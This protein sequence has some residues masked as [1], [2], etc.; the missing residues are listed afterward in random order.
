MKK[1]M[2]AVILSGIVLF[3]WGFFSWAVLPWHNTVANEFTSEQTVA[4]VL[5]E[6]APGAGVYY[7]PFAEE[8]RGAGETG[9][10][11]NVLPDGFDMNMGKLMGQALLGQM[12]AAFLVLL[13]LRNTSGLAY[14]Q[15]VGF[16]ALVGLT[17]GFV[18]HFPYWNW[19]GFSAAYVIV[20]ILDSLIAWTLAGL[21]MAR[22]VDGQRA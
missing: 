20:I 9:A 6:N 8:D 4:R 22:L 14:M 13:L 16:V 17:I 10:F 2:L 11:V 3:L 18:G 7:L 1:Y 5:R 12:M 21:V 19:F 15:R